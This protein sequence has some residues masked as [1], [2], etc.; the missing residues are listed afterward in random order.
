MGVRLFGRGRGA[1]VLMVVMVGWR[2]KNWRE[3]GRVGY[4]LRG[5]RPG[6][7][8]LLLIAEVERWFVGLTFRILGF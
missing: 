3:D 2:K 1:I 4:R 7:S 6:L 5:S 8:V